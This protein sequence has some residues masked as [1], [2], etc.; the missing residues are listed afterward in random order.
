M[1]LIPS[2]RD[3]IRRKVEFVM[4]SNDLIISITI[5]GKFG[6]NL[7]T[8]V[9]EPNKFW[10]NLITFVI[11]TKQ[12]LFRPYY[13]RSQYRNFQLNHAAIPVHS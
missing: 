12:L 9:I 2:K 4:D 7:I 5:T 1:D 11:K 10:L 13:L 3:F 8:S 6:F